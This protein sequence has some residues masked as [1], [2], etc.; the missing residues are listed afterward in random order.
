MFTEVLFIVMLGLLGTAQ[1]DA[2]QENKDVLYS[3]YSRPL[4][5]NKKEWLLLYSAWMNVTGVRL[6]EVLE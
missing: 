3:S 5:N 1:P 4:L 2:Q 6:S